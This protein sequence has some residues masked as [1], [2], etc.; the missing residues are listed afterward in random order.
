MAFFR[1]T[2][3]GQ[4]SAKTRRQKLWRIA[5]TGLLVATALGVIGIFA[6][7]MLAAWVS[8]DLPDPNALV[9]R[10]IPQSHWSKPV[11]YSIEQ[12]RGVG[13][14]GSTYHP[15]Q[16]T[17]ADLNKDQTAYSETEIY[18]ST[19]EDLIKAFVETGL[20][21]KEVAKECMSEMDFNWY[22]GETEVV[23][24]D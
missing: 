22:F 13:F 16:L 1:P 20:A 5:K 18:E 8:R 17:T 15:A 10:D 21:N 14:W 9:A 6:F 23:E 3:P 19:N 7:T 24:E 11:R 4:T 12:R 2:G